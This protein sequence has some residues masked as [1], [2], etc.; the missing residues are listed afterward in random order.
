[1]MKTLCARLVDLLWYWC[2]GYRFGDTDGWNRLI[3]SIQY[4][5][6]CVCRRS[7]RLQASA[8]TPTTHALRRSKANCRKL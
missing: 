2:I 4:G 6:M 7:P 1:M 3:N 8:N 5:R